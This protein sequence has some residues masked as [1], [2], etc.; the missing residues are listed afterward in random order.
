LP[1]LAPMKVNCL[2]HT[3]HVKLDMKGKLFFV[4]FIMVAICFYTPDSY[5]ELKKIADDKKDLCDTYTDW[6]IE[7]TKAVQRIKEQGLEVVPITIDI[8]ELK[9]WCK[10]NKLKN[11]GSSRSKYV[12]ELDRTCL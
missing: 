2:S 12:A 10:K 4:V 6:L 3:K 9:N 7:F 8:D 1:L 5:T 11:T